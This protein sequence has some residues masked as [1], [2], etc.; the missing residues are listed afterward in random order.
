[1]ED[2]QVLPAGL[3]CV[4]GKKF[5]FCLKAERR[6]LIRTH[7]CTHTR[8]SDI[9]GR[10]VVAFFLKKNK[11]EAKRI[12]KLKRKP[13]NSY[14]RSGRKQRITFHRIEKKKISLHL[15]ADQHQRKNRLFCCVP[16][17]RVWSVERAPLQ[18]P[19]AVRREI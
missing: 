4:S 13:K 19:L 12:E 17:G 11:K 2:P 5:E 16:R 9:S 1:M 15:T 6:E 7:Q 8:A 10:R 18:S 3:D 14:V